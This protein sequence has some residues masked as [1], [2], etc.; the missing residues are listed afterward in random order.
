MDVVTGLIKANVPSR[1]AFA[2]SS[3]SDSR[4][5]LDQPGAEKLVGKGDALFL[6]MGS[7]KPIRLQNAWVSE[8]EIRAVVDHC[9]KQAKPAYRD[10][11]GVAETKKKQIDE[12]IGDDLDL[13]SASRRARGHHPV[14]LHVHAATQAPRRLR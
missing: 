8:K 5:I 10:D 3:L 12:E 4:V 11:V 13:L 1:L 2:T 7:S 9:K 14:R 6:P